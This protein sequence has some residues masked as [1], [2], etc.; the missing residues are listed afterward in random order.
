MFRIVRLAGKF[1]AVE[2]ESIEDDIDDANVFLE[3]GTAIIYVN[4]IADFD[5]LDITVL[6]KPIVE[7]VS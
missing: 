3:D 5:D 6:R 7:L 2:I 1:K 4:S